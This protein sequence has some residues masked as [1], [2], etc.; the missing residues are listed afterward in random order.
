MQS[1][2]RIGLLVG[3]VGCEPLAA[4]RVNSVGKALDDLYGSVRFHAKRIKTEQSETQENM[5]KLNAILFSDNE[6]ARLEERL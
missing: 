2:D 3:G 1:P 4:V 6:S 5:V